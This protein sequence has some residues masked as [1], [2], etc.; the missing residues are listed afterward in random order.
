MFYTYDLKEYRDYLRG[1]NFDFENEAPGPLLETYDE[2]KDAL[3]HID[4]VSKE[5]DDAL[6]K[7]RNKFNEYEHRSASKQ[8]F[9]KVFR[10]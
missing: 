6:Q 8:I 1:F 5:Y 3:L 2:L 4:Q 9:E 7:F 10:K